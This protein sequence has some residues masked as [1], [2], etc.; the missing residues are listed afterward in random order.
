M[1]LEF[2]SLSHG[3][4][5][6]GF[7]NIETDMILLNQYFLFAEDFCGYI[8][9]V[10]RTNE[11]VFKASWEAYSFQNREDIGNLMGAIHGIDHSGFIG[12]VYKLYPFPKRQED[13]KQKSEG[14]KTRPL[15]ESKI[16]KY[17][18]K[19]NLRFVIDPTSQKI[20]IG[21]YLFDTIVF[22]KLIQYIWQGGFPQWKDGVR[23]DYLISMKK[24]IDASRNSICSDLIL[25]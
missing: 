25:K 12:E 17:A 10:V 18:L 19:M 3:K 13:F 16:R 11:I 15:I 1:P 24:D 21:E 7:F 22:Q 14:F 23:P 6:F 20:F 4:I 2:E 9:Q 5:A 8:S